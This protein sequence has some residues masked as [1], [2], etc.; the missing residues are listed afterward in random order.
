MKKKNLTFTV[1]SAIGIILILLGHLDL[2]VLSFGGLFPY[3][4]YHVMIFVFISGYF[5]KPEDEDDIF[6]FILRKAKRLLL[7]YFIWN[8]IYGMIAIPMRS[9]GFIFAG[10]FDLYNLF[11][12]PFM[13]GHQFGLNAAAW[14]VPALFLLQMCDM[15]ARKIASVPVK[16]IGKRTDKASSYETLLK[17]GD[18]Q[19]NEKHDTT[20]IYGTAAEWI[21]MM[22]YLATGVAA[23]WLSQRGS[24][25]DAY[26]LPARLMLMAPAFQFGRLYK[27]R[28]EKYDITPWFLYFPLIFGMNLWLTYVHGGLAYSTVWVTGFAGT[29]L[30]PFITSLTGIALWLRVSRIVAM[31][32]G[33]RKADSPSCADS[34]SSSGSSV[35]TEGKL[36]ASSFAYKIFNSIGTHTYDIMMHHLAVFMLIKA[37]FALVAENCRMFADFDAAAFKED[38]YYTYAPGGVQAVKL[39]YLIPGLLIPIGIGMLQACISRHKRKDHKI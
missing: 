7:P 25:Y 8:I 12:A 19:K 4:S 16:I 18:D 36:N 15:A 20:V 33:K 1:L 22:M 31:L 14:F 35:T 37:V 32:I 29:A 9:S 17:D 21:F 3:Y 10:E 24:V 11:V 27:T 5:Y 30:T 39:I 2:N 6:G 38:L 28:L 23:V 34:P 13:G 26:R